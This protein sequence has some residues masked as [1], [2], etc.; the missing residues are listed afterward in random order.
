MIGSGNGL[1]KNKVLC[2][3]AEK[4]FGMKLTLSECKEEAA[5]GAAISGCL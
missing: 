4:M 3:I 1:R 2:E 5:T